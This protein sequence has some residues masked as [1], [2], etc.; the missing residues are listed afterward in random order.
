VYHT[1]VEFASVLRFMEETFAL[2]NLGGADTIANDLQDAFNYTQTP[3]APL[4]LSQ[5]TC[6]K[7][8]E[9]TPEF[10]PDDLED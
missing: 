10:D 2:P 4:V 8:S 6:P 1:E 3:L 9:D 7:A 5:R